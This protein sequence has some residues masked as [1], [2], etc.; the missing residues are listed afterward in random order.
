[1]SSLC[2][3]CRPVPS[4]FPGHL[5]GA[6]RLLSP[7]QWPLPAPPRLQPMAEGGLSGQ[8]MALSDMMCARQQAWGS[9]RPPDAPGIPE[10]SGEPCRL[11]VQNLRAE[12]G[13]QGAPGVGQ[14]PSPQAGGRRAAALLEGERAA[15][16]WLWHLS[17]N[18]STRVDL[19]VREFER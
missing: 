12:C 4:A 16:V 11:E 14:K 7:Q 15:G 13:V 1:M 9:E 17:G 18:K 6:Q 5:F 8:L 10:P 19:L 3:A 2:L